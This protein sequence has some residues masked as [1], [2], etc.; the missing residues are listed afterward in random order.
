MVVSSLVLPQSDGTYG[1]GRTDAAGRSIQTSDDH[2][3][4]LDL[5]LAGIGQIQIG[6]RDKHGA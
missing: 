1:Y 4:G 3:A 5:A 6:G 2:Q